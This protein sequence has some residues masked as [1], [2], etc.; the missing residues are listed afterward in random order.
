[1]LLPVEYVVLLLWLGVT[2]NCQGLQG[3]CVLSFRFNRIAALVCCKLYRGTFDI[4]S[5]VVAR[6]RSQRLLL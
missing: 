4:G 1:M 2:S 6:L 3:R 5:L